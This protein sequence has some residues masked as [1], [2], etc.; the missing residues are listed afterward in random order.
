MVG[1]AMPPQPLD[2]RDFRAVFDRVVDTS[3]SVREG[4][5][6]E[7]FSAFR[8][9]TRQ[10][11]PQRPL[12]SHHGFVYVLNQLSVLAQVRPHFNL[13]KGVIRHHPLALRAVG[14]CCL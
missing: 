3:C 10:H 9:T 6:L 4:L 8:I 5:R 13:L 11:F 12:D 2:G 14:E 7:I 1:R